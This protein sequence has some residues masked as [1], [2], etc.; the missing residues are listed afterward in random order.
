MNERKSGRS[1]TKAFCT[2][3]D[4]EKKLEAVLYLVPNRELYAFLLHVLRNARRRNA[5]ALASEFARFP[6]TAVLIDARAGTTGRLEGCST[7]GNT[8]L[9][10]MAP[11]CLSLD[12]F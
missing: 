10:P 5:I 7:E 2:E 9:N 11:H 4:R 1:G 8:S 12:Q 6:R 3:L